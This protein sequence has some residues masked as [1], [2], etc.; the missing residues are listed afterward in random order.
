MED[1]KQRR[2]ERDAAAAEENQGGAETQDTTPAA[3][4][5]AKPAKAKK[6]SARRGRSQKSTRATQD[7]PIDHVRVA[8]GAL[9]SIIGLAAH[10]VPGVVGMAP[11]NIGEGL[12]RILGAR[13][14]D[15]GVSVEH[16]HGESRAD[17]DI[18]VV[19]AYGV[20][21]PVVAEG[22]RERVRYAARQFAGV[23]LDEVR[24]HVEGV[25]RG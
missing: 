22:V 12:R 17:V 9:R 18:H 7:R 25:S 11:V 20:N 13:Q 4:A 15:E 24:V 10:E 2:A 1:D 14:V 23:S 16:P 3:D 21:I 5:K 19:V 8:D 6:S